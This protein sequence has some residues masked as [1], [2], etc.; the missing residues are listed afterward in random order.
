MSVSRM[1]P[2]ILHYP[3]CPAIAARRVENSLTIMSSLVTP[4]DTQPNSSCRAR[5]KHSDSYPWPVIFKYRMSQVKP[6]PNAQ[7]FKVSDGKESRA[8]PATMHSSAR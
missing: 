4:C 3:S 5:N 1:H 8:S 2:H 7:Y 6:A